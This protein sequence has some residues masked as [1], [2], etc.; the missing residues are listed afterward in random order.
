MKNTTQTKGTETMKTV[1]CVELISDAV[2]YV[3]HFETER[4]AR[5]D[6]SR[7]FQIYTMPSIF[8]MQVA[9]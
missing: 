1:W 7:I 6:A 3:R 9:A 4:E 2:L 5:R 8:K